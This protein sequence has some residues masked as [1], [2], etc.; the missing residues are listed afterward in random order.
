MADET[1]KAGPTMETP[2]IAAP[3]DATTN[4]FLTESLQRDV[5]MSDAPVDQPAVCNSFSTS[6]F[7]LNSCFQAATLSNT[8]KKKT[9]Y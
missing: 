2:Q 9:L 1:P 4:G 8:F 3:A 6:H 5:V 7:Y